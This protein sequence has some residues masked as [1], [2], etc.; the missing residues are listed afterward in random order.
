MSMAVPTSGPDDWFSDGTAPDSPD[1]VIKRSGL[2]V[3]M[4]CLTVF[5]C[6]EFRLL[7]WV[8]RG[9]DMAHGD[10]VIVKPYSRPSLEV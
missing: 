2:G 4:V 1:G 3:V 8:L 10:G 5:V 6:S 9:C 7:N